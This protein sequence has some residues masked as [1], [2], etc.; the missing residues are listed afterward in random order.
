M[1]KYISCVAYEMNVAMFLV[2]WHDYKSEGPAVTIIIR[3]VTRAVCISN[4]IADG[5]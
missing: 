2:Y 4:P 3:I 5:M 1:Y